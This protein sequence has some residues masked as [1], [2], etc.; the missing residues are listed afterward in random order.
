MNDKKNIKSF[1]VSDIEKYHKNEL[2]P[3]RRH[4]LEKAA[5]EDPFLADAL[6]GYEAH[7][8]RMADDINELKKNILQKTLSPTGKNKKSLIRR[9]PVWAKAAAAL[10]L[11]GGAGLITYKIFKPGKEHTLTKTETEKN[12][13]WQIQHDTVISSVQ[14]PPHETFPPTATS[15]EK[16]SAQKTLEVN[17]NKEYESVTL[18]QK[19]QEI[20]PSV[21]TSQPALQNSDSLP[22]PTVQ[23]HEPEKIQEERILILDRQKNPEAVKKQ[24]APAGNSAKRE[25]TEENA[26]GLVVHLKENKQIQRQSV[27]P[28]ILYPI[29]G[30]IT[31]YRG[32]ALEGV[33]IT[34]LETK[35]RVKSDESGNFMFLS[36]DTVIKV[37]IELSGFRT[38]RTTLKKDIQNIISLKTKDN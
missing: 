32:N 20:K 11:L 1:T 25:N 19:Q 17:K 29:K 14:N 5:L 6:E 31:D 8:Q 9:I 21:T 28:K 16:E 15:T 22:P 38:V 27:E 4:E 12:E 18:P 36:A 23:I 24:P 7:A 2:P 3:S 35:N 13:R 34:N 37:K 33:I 10:I 30:V 26:E